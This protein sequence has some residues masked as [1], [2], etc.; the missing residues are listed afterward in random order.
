VQLWTLS[1]NS[2]KERSFPR[3]KGIAA[4]PHPAK[5]QTHKGQGDL[6]GDGVSCRRRHEFGSGRIGDRLPQNL[7]DRRGS[8]GV[9]VPVDGARHSF[10]F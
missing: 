4:L 7:I 3:T 10:Q 6:G 2:D 5:A 9:K 8:I 1:G